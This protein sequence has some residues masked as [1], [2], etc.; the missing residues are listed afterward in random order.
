[1]TYFIQLYFMI[2]F[3]NWFNRLFSVF[4]DSGIGIQ[5]YQ[6]LFCVRKHVNYSYTCSLREDVIMFYHTW[7]LTE[8]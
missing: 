2:I 3:L 8:D 5:S 7:V 6:S 4:A 1:L